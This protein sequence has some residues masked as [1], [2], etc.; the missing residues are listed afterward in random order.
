MW[1]PVPQTC[2]KAIH[3]NFFATWPGLTAKLV[4]KHL[5]EN[6]ETSRGKMRSNR[7]NV[8]STKLLPNQECHEMTTQEVQ[9]H[10]FFIKTVE[11]SG[12]IYSDQ[13]GRL[14]LTSSNGNRYVMVVYNHDYNAILAEPLKSRSAEH[15]LAATAKMHILL[16]E[17]GINPKIYIMD[18]ECSSTVRSYLKNN[19]IELQLVPTNLHRT[20]A[21]EKE[22][23]IFKDHFI[24]GLATVH[25]SFPL[26]IWCRL[27]PL[28]DTTLNL[29]RPSR[30][31]PK[32]SA[33]EILNGVFDYNKTPIAPPGCKIVVHEP[34]N[35][36]GTWDIHGV[37]GWYLGM[38]PDHYRCHRVY[39]PKMRAE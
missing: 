22:I 21:T 5:K 20:N 3:S 39:I 31:N 17:R 34:P 13:T 27:I 1:N 37:D 12:N 28:A 33:Y 30:I 18:N 26:H 15:L 7:A 32:L 11:L 9:H 2:I 38:A 14:P 36:R 23:G 24:S 25:P 29:M 8:R 4:Q 6:I 10:G 35:K 19:N 16:R